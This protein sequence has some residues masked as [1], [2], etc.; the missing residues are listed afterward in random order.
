MKKTVFFWVCSLFLGMSLG[1]L[2]LQL[3]P[4]LPSQ[5]VSPLA[6]VSGKRPAKILGFLP[7]WLLD[8]AS[9]SYT[10][11]LT[12]LAYFSLPIA[13]D[14]SIQKMANPQEEEPGWT[15]LKKQAVADRMSQAH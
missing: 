6:E 7:Y 11:S 12:T 14:G 3:L 2:Y 8:K 5:L 9:P 4:Q 1:V 15:T 10:N 13:K